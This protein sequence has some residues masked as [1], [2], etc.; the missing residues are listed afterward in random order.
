VC[1]YERITGAEQAVDA[2]VEP[3]SKF[4]YHTHPQL[5]GVHDVILFAFE[6]S[7]VV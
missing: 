5:A 2:I 1:G 4:S 7:K 6:W 3:C